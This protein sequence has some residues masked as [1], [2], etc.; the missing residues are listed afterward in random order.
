MKTYRLTSA[1]DHVVGNFRQVGYISVEGIASRI[2]HISMLAA[3]TGG[4]AYL[5]IYLARNFGRLP[6]DFKIGPLEIVVGIVAFALTAIA[7][8][9]M[10]VLILRAYGAKPKFGI[11]RNNGLVYISVPDYGFRRNSLIVTALIPLV[12][13]T[14]L[15]LVGIWLFQGTPWVALFALIAVVNAAASSAD[16]WVVAMLLRYPSRAWAVD[17]ERG[18]MCILLPME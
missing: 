1:Q 3:I 15:S 14:A 11:F 10:H 7:Q 13:L 17:D 9:W 18:G 2:A 16:L 5:F 8:E 4:M 12:V 6:A